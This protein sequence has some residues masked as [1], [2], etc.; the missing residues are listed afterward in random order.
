VRIE[1]ITEY[2]R[3]G[4]TYHAHPNYNSVG[5]WYDWAM[6]RFELENDN[7]NLQEEEEEGYYGKIFFLQKHFVLYVQRMIQFMLSFIAAIQIITV[8]T[9]FLWNIGKMNL[10][11]RTTC[12]CLY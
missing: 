10:K 5:E 1:I 8:K 11:W 7:T 2:K 9:V 3:N 4:V 12:L 6:V